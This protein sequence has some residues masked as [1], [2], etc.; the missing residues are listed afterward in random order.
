RRSHRGRAPSGTERRTDATGGG[1]GTEPHPGVD[2][3]ATE[4]GEEG[5]VAARTGPRLGR[6]LT[7]R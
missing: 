5:R 4:Q 2:V 1:G 6:R 7:N 3:D